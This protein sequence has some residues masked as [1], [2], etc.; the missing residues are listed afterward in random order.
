MESISINI[1]FII[2]TKHI[3]RQIIQFLKD[4]YLKGDSTKYN[5]PDNYSECSLQLSFSQTH[6]A[7]GR[8]K[9]AAREE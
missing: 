6:H 9:L 1:L 2:Q 7:K 5:I 4:W 3:H 8:Q